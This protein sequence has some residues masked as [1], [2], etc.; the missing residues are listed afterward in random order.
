MSEEEID[1]VYGEFGAFLKRGRGMVSHA[2][3]K[4]FHRAGMKDMTITEHN[5]MHRVTKERSRNRKFMLSNGFAILHFNSENYDIWRSR[6]SFRI[7]HQSFRPELAGVVQGFMDGGDEE[8][9]SRLF[10]TLNVFGQNR[11]SKHADIKSLQVIEDSFS[12]YVEK[13]F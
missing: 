1:Q 6:L 12:R 9:L 11:L 10:D 4:S 2:F 7:H 3:G 5:A 8:S 13:Y